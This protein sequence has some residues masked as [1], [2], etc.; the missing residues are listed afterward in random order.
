MKTK[1]YGLWRIINDKKLFVKGYVCISCEC[2]CGTVRMVNIK[3]LK[4]GRS[5]NCGCVRNAQTTQRNTKHNKRFT[6]EWAIWQAMKTRCS[7]KNIIQ[8][9]NYGGRGIKVCDEWKNSFISFY[10]DMGKSPIGSSIDRID[11]NGNYCKENCRWATSREQTRNKANN[12][13]IDGICFVDIDK[14]L[15][16]KSGVVSRRLKRG[17]SINDATKLKLGTYV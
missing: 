6:R 13:K 10:N 4:S 1:K 9:K 8:Y 15:G 17:W 12:R 5:T 3:N 16:G 11:N 2:K 14:K 7:N